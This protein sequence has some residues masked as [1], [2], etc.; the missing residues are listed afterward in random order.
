MTCS[1]LSIPYIL[2]LGIIVLLIA[3]LAICLIKK[4]N[5]QNHKFSSIV[6]VV[7]SLA[8]ELNRLKAFISTTIQPKN[9][10]KEIQITQN[11][12]V[13]IPVSDNE[14]EEESDEEEEEE[15]EEEESDDEEEEESDE[16]EDVKLIKLNEEK[17]EISSPASETIISKIDETIMSNTVDLLEQPLQVTSILET[18]L[19]EAPILTAALEEPEIEPEQ[20]EEQDIVT[21]NIV[22]PTTKVNYKRLPIIQLRN[23]AAE[24]GITEDLTKFK[25]DDIIKLLNEQ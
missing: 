18:P 16:E 21:N 25:K 11:A 4:M 3:G 9:E 23:I 17:P 20:E 7:T 1:A 22:K 19:L 24:K 6:G 8:E 13:K 2:L 12:M 5:N 14:E 15:E 10:V